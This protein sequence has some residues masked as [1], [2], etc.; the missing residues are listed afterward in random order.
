MGGMHLRYVEPVGDTAGAADSDG[1]ANGDH[2]LDE[3]TLCVI[4]MVKQ[5][6]HVGGIG[7]SNYS[8]CVC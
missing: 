8:T 2:V 7:N 6:A 1:Q 5:L 3:P 4:N